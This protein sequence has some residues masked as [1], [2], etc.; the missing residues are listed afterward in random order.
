MLRPV[1]ADFPEQCAHPA[2]VIRFKQIQFLDHTRSAV[3]VKK[4]KLFFF[5]DLEGLRYV[6]PSGVQV[7]IPTTAFSSYILSNL[8]AHNPAALPIYNK[9]LTL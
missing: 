8:T 3:P 6:L 2:T 4:D 1:R 9:A 5:A 7:D